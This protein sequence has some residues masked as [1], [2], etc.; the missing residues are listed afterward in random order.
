[1]LIFHGEKSVVD[2]VFAILQKQNLNGDKVTL[3]NKNARFDGIWYEPG[4]T[5]KEFDGVRYW[6]GFCY[7]V[8]ASVKNTAQ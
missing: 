2:Q 8:A 3:Q 5:G 6:T 1:M 4:P 7:G